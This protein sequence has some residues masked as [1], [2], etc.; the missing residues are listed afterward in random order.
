[1]PPEFCEGKCRKKTENE[2]KK[3]R[4]KQGREAGERTSCGAPSKERGKKMGR[5]QL[6]LVATNI[7]IRIF[8]PQCD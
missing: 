6:N 2:N 4:Q 5:E 3:E 7:K 8:E 1:M